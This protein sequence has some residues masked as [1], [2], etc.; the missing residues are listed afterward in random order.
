MLCFVQEIHNKL[1]DLIA[2]D[3][4]PSIIHNY[5]PYKLLRDM[6]EQ[7]VRNEEALLFLR[8]RLHYPEKYLILNKSKTFILDFD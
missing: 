3:R 2:Y 6:K 7:Q 8:R 4:E 1:E 5:N